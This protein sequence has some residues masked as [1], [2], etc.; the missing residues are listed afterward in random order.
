MRMNVTLR[1]LRVFCAVYERRSFTSAAEEMHMT[2][3]AVSKLCAELE[4]EIGMPLFE[5]TTRRVVPCDGAAGL[6]ED[7]QQVLDTMRLAGRR[8]SALRSLERGAIAITAS[9]MMMHGILAPVLQSFCQAHPEVRIDLHELTTDESIDHVKT[10]KCDFGLVALG[11]PDP[12]LQARVVCA[13]PLYLACHGTHALA[14]QARASWKDIAGHP[15]ISLGSVYSTRRTI[16]GLLRA[17][18][19]SLQS[20][21]Q[22]GTLGTALRLVQAGLGVTL[23]P[24]YARQFA[25]DAGLRVLDIRD[26]RPYLHELSL[27]TRKGL[28]PSIAAAAFMDA[29]VAHLQS[30]HPA[31]A[32]A[33]PRRPRPGRHTPPA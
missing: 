12:L 28:K 16:D 17:R 10:G 24:G 23:V 31:R 27:L 29:L 8:L 33:P 11:E 4:S 5:R 22:A 6:Y 15:H 3:S 26:T 21:I 2:Q 30:R 13:E 9:P 19:L 1:Q 20:T 32:P 14:A 25:L 18:G 7:A